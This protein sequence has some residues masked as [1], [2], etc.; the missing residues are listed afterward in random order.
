MD[1][2]VLL[3]ADDIH[4]ADD[5]TVAL[6]RHVLERGRG[7]RIL[8]VATQRDEAPAEG[9]LAEA[10]SRLAREELADEVPLTA[11]PS[12]RSPSCLSAFR[13]ATSQTSWWPRLLASQPEIRFS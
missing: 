9:A 13:R 12:P 10:L 8:I 3:V 7:A 1:A 2:P 4:W 11:F 6:L 5:S